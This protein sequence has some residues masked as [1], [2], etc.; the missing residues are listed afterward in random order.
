MKY[1]VIKIQPIQTFHRWKGKLYVRK[2]SD[3][4]ILC[5]YLYCLSYLLKK[6]LSFKRN[7]LEATQTWIINK[8]S[9]ALRVILK[10]SREETKSVFWLVS[11]SRHVN[12]LT[13]D[14]PSETH[15]KH[16]R[17]LSIH[18]NLTLETVPS[19]N[20]KY[21]LHCGEYT[22]RGADNTQPLT[23]GNF[24]NWGGGD[25]KWTEK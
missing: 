9:G 12:L 4:F 16:R 20:Q 18:C 24:P 11:P 13:L 15:G 2:S 8:T 17:H 21:L 22:R 6:F 3:M 25:H 23:T 1:S 14:R 19:S 5:E 10:R 7:Q